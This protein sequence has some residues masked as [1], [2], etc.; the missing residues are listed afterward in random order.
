MKVR[1]VVEPL[2]HEPLVDAVDHLASLL[3]GGVETEIHQDDET[4]EGNKQASVLIRQIVSPPAVAPAP[5]TGRRLESEKLGSPALGCDARP[6]G[7]NRVGGFCVEVL[8]DLPTDGRVKIEEP[9]NVR[10]AG[11]VIVSAHWPFLAPG[12][13]F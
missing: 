5:V 9:F 4:V 2:K 6:L 12:F 7:C 1:P 8:H 10:G 13:W 11:C 3:A